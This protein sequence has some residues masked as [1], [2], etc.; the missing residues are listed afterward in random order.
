[1]SYSNGRA[2]RAGMP[3]RGDRQLS[4]NLPLAVTPLSSAAPFRLYLLFTVVTFLSLPNWFPAIGKL[5]PTVLLMLV[6]IGLLV[7]NR[8]GLRGRLD[9]VI[10][11]RLLLLIGYVVLSL[12]FVVWPGSV[13]RN[14]FEPFVKSIAFFFF[15][16]LIIDS[17]ARLRV[18][19]GV[20][21]ACQIYRVLD[22]LRRHIA[23]GYWGSST[24]LGHGEFMDRLSGAPWDIINPNGLGLVIVTAFIFVYYLMLKSP[25]LWVR[26]LGIAIIPPLLYALA[27]TSS[28]S[29]FI[30]LVVAFAMIVYR[31]KRRML[32]VAI[33]IMSSSFAYQHMAPEQQERYLSIFRDDV[34]GSE[35][36]AGRINGW[37][38]DIQIWRENP[39]VGTGIGTSGE[40][41]FHTTG[42][43]QVSHNM[44]TE[45]LMETGVIGLAI[46][47]AMLWAIWT[48]SSKALRAPALGQTRQASSDDGYMQR[49]GLAL[50]AWFVMCAVFSLA[51]Y[52]LSQ[53]HWYLFGGLSVVFGRLAHQ[54]ETDVS[55]ATL[56]Q[57][58]GSGLNTR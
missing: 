13:L 27:L 25:K 24:H 16:A 48:T 22:P 12:P 56:H 36:A 54:A 39:I 2:V 30:V 23:Y 26:L 28:R 50:Q 37:S 11:K 46:V 8:E 1:M 18:F 43:Y 17:P 3:A 20:F 41:R 10:S 31:S 55:A 19:L 51:Q 7:A 33:A 40:A 38:T 32:L 45:T 44:Y 52:G 14:N 49:L 15:T 34:R 5:R 9:S 29:G 53:Y 21:L 6:L 35:T 58:R 57:S 47:I 4:S 42:K